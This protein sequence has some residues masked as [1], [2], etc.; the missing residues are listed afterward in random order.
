T[1]DQPFDVSVTGKLEGARP[2]ANA[3]VNIQGLVKLDPVTKLYSARNLEANIKG[4]VGD[5][6]VQT[7][8]LTGDFEIDSFAHALAGSGIEVTIPGKGATGTGLRD[9]DMTL[10]APKL[11]FDSTAPLLQMTN[12][13]V[14]GTASDEDKESYEWV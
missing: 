9:L 5:V 6:D 13:A 14:K 12:F 8:T 1:F 3:N 10:A 4:V 2:V 7:G 11:N